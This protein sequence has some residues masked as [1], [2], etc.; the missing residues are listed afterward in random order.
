[1]TAFI[2]MFLRFFFLLTPF[3]V[4][5][6]FLAWTDKLDERARKRLAVRV[7]VAVLASSVCLAVAGNVIFELFGITLDA[8]RV[9]AGALLFLS[10]VSLVRGDM[11]DAARNIEGDI[12][13]V[14][15]ALPITLGPA[16]IGAL[17][18]MSA[19]RARA[20]RED[21]IIW[22]DLFLEA[23]GV[24]TAILVVGTM[25][26]VAAY[27]ERLLG[28][29]GLVVMSKLTGLFLSAMS[30]QMMLVGARQL[31]NSNIT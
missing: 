26:Y 11:S 29:R 21:T 20:I 31:W 7:T 15:L 13:I 9:G 30:A 28:R 14:P 16:T 10:S 2:T 24:I 25:L 27:V 22:R 18:V 12:A 5:S 8:F 19:D 23:A 3:F 6:T 17:M 4:M 1:M